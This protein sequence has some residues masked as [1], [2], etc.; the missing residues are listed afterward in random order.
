MARRKKKGKIAV[1]IILSVLIL[2]AAGICIFVFNTPAYVDSAKEKTG[3]TNPLTGEQVE[4]LPAR[5]LIVS[6]DN[7]GE[8]KPQLGISK[9]DIVYEVPVEGSQSRL[10]AIYYSEIPETVGPCRSVRSY[11]VDLAREYNAILVHNGYS[12]QARE[13][14]EQGSVAYIPAQKYSFFTE[15]MQSLRRTTALWTQKTC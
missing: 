9:A 5:P 4:T 3:I 14:L 12:P 1:I 15:P 6:T 8:A 10:E 2:A 7:V 13:Y 11:I